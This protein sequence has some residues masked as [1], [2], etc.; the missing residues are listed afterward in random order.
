[1]KTKTYSYLLIFFLTGSIFSG[2]FASLPNNNIIVSADE[3]VWEN[4]YG[5]LS[6]EPATST[7]LIRQHQWYNLTWYYPDNTVDIAFGFN[8]SLSYG[9]I[10]YWD[11]DSYNTVSTGHT[12]YGG[13]HYYTVSDINV[14]QDNTIHG[15][16]EYDVPPGTSGKWDL[17]AKL[18]SDSWATAFSTGR[19]IH[20]DPWWDSNWLKVKDV[21]I[22]HT[23]VP[24]ALTNFPILINLSSTDMMGDVQADLG[25]IV[26]TNSLNN[27]IMPHEI[28]WYEINATNVNALIWVNVSSVNGVADGA[29]THI[30]MYYK[31][32]GCGNQ[33]NPGGTWD[34]DYE[35]VYHLNE[36][37]GATHADDS[38][39]NANNGSLNGTIP[40]QRS[41]KIGN[42]QLLD[43]TNDYIH[44]IC[45]GANVTEAGTIEFWV[46]LQGS[47][48][49]QFFCSMH[50][51]A[52]NTVRMD[53]GG[54]SKWV[55]I[56]D[57]GGVNAWSNTTL[58]VNTTLEQ[59]VYTWADDDVKMFVSGNQIYV[60]T[61]VDA[62]S[63]TPDNFWF[64]AN[65]NGGDDLNATMDEIRASSTRRSDSWIVANYNTVNNMTGVNPFVTISGEVDWSQGATDTIS[66]FNVSTNS[67][68]QMTLNWTQ[69]TNGNYT[70]IERNTISSWSIGDGTFLYNA[71]NIGTVDSNVTAYNVYYYNA[72][73]F[74]ESTHNFSAYTSANNHTGPLN[75]TSI[76]PSLSGGTLNFTW[77]KGTRGDTTVIVRKHNSFSDSI[78]DGTQVYNG[79][80]TGYDDASFNT[81][82]YYTFYGF[83]S[84][85]S[86]SSSGIQTQ[87]GVL[88][89]R[90]FDENTSAVIYNYTV[91]V[92]NQSGSETYEIY[93]ANTQVINIGIANLPT[94][95]D[96][97]IKINAT[98]FDGNWSAG[99]G[100]CDNTTNTT[101][102]YEDRV[103]YMDINP[104]TFYNLSA[105]LP[106]VVDSYLY[107]L[108]V[109]GPK[110]EYN[111]DP[112]I[113]GA[114]M[115]IKR[116]INSSVGWESVGIYLTDGDGNIYVYLIPGEIYKVTT[117]ASGYLTDISDYIP[118]DTVFEQRFRLT[119]TTT[120]D[121]VIVYD[122]FWS[123][124]TIDIDMVSS[125]RFS[126]ETYQFGNIT[127]EFSDSNGSIINTQIRL[128]EIYGNNA[129]LVATWD[130]S[131]SSFNIVRGGINTTRVYYISVHFNSSA[132]YYDIQPIIILIPNVDTSF[133]VEPFNLD[134]RITKIIG[135][136]TMDGKE[137]PWSIVIGIIIPIIVLVSFGPFNTGLGIISCGISMVMV[138]G[139]LSKIIIGGFSWGVAGL[140]VFIIIIGILYV[141]TKGQ[142]SD[143]L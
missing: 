35:F 32:S 21:Y 125:G 47:T 62:N 130:N 54:N 122:D 73:A 100:D 93:S 94:G 66:Y 136:F 126:N 29:D 33:A 18:S 9:Q 85:T 119:P 140:G 116:Y 127:I 16:W 6:V 48:V 71:T 98:V 110:D 30:R 57:L 131:S 120:P 3:V 13:D 96:V 17:Y 81:S 53:T 15:Y 34:S 37:T 75:P 80:A 112:P 92:T 39:S 102:E 77:T 40:V 83:N 59:V 19:V 128:Y 46:D 14:V 124:V 28:D 142:G 111:A 137:V 118:S 72:W 56:G 25:D 70:Y 31:N 107:R 89:V 10:Y 42:G 109:V 121:G 114:T 106:R 123:D 64:G 101:I 86:L 41:V 67:K 143:Q 52:S 138:Q 82:S 78:S 141:M 38:T 1:M 11:G 113:Q 117:S 133:Y 74:N 50:K 103:Y 23:Q 44:P 87:W 105:Y 63:F 132:S 27:T 7:N 90:V 129:T 49:D 61:S 26:F 12:E 45:D 108:S 36:T 43:G 97:V 4:E 139:F 51:D 69:S 115:D 58:D 24:I 95:E 91:F 55:F 65:Q 88:Q 134:D 68:T 104:N 8:D 22:D 76:N 99:C 84:L 60:D 135:P 79:S 2:M 20:L 5:R